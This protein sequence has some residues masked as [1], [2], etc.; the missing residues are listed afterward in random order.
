MKIVPQSAPKRTQNRLKRLSRASFFHL[1]FRLRFFTN[2]GPILAPKMAPLG[3]PF[4]YQNRLQNRSK[5]DLEKRSPQESSKTRQELPREAPGRPKRAPGDP[6]SRPGG[7][8]GAQNL[9]NP[10]GF[11]TKTVKSLFSDLP[12]CAF[13]CRNLCVSFENVPVA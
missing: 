10:A 4:R 2:F 12:K 7:S 9:E 8:P 13:S 3:H 5:F 11:C 6:K 1:R